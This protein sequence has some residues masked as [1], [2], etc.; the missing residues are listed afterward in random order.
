MKDFKRELKFLYFN[1]LLILFVSFVIGT[2]TARSVF[3]AGRSWR[4]KVV[5]GELDFTKGVAGVVGR[6]FA[7]LFGNTKV[8]NGNHHLHV[9][10]KLNH[11]EKSNCGKYGGCAALQIA[12]NVAANRF[13]YTVRYTANTFITVSDF[14]DSC[15]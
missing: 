1:S 12:Y 3:G 13:A 8:I 14:A 15:R 11:C 5:K 6:A 4:E 2:L 7:G 10:D 9:A